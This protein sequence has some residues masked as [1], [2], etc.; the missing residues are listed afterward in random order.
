M[1]IA[2]RGIV[3]R[4]N[5]VHLIRRIQPLQDL[6]EEAIHAKDDEVDDTGE[7][8]NFQRPVSRSYL[9]RELLGSGRDAPLHSGPK[10]ERLRNEDVFVYYL[11]TSSYLLPAIHA[12]DAAMSVPWIVLASQDD[13]HC[14]GYRSV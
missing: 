2:T 14:T 7:W 10:T 5:V 3:L 6:K 8:S 1:G 11:G 13:F 9:V 12:G 4:N